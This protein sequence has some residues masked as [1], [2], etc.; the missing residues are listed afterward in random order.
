MYV[1]AHMYMFM[2]FH[3]GFM[4]LLHLFYFFIYINISSWIVTEALTFEMEMRGHKQVTAQ[5]HVRPHY[6]R[7]NFEHVKNSNR[8]KNIISATTK[9]EFEFESAN[10]FPKSPKPLELVSAG[11]VLSGQ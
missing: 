4:F 3:N 7:L 6:L 1:Y 8:S 5:A 10:L 11:M 9:F 2:T